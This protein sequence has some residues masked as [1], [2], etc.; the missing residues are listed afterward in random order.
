MLCGILE[1]GAPCCLL[2]ASAGQSESWAGCGAM[3]QLQQALQQAL[4]FLGHG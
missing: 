2:V 4:I 1:R 3:L